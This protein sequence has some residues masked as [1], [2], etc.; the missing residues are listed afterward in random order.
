M[1][2][3]PEKFNTK[4]KVEKKMLQSSSS[5]AHKFLR[6]KYQQNKNLSNET[7]VAFYTLQQVVV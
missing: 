2:E 1:N 6:W 7:I 5:N 4:I 3:N